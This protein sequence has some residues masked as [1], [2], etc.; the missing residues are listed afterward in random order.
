MAEGMILSFCALLTAAPFF[1]LSLQK[2]DPRE[3][4]P[5]FSGDES[6][7]RD[8]SDIAAYNWEM[9]LL[10]RR[11]AAHLAF[12]ALLALLSP[13]LALILLGL[14]ISL[15]LFIVHR[16]YKAIRTKHTYSQKG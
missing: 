11:Y 10:Y 14:L 6:L 8:L 16:R 1:A 12:A 15:G 3:P 5:F 4:I 2:D 9:A 7:K 13:L